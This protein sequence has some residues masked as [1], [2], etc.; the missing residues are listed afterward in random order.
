MKFKVGIGQD[1]HR[2]EKGI[3]RALMLG[4][5]EIPS[6]LSLQGNSDADLVL[7][8]LCNAIS[9]ISGKVI[10]GPFTDKLCLEKGITDSVE[11]VKETVKTLKKYKI[12]HVSVAIECAKPKIVPHIDKM[13]SKLAAI[14]NI[15]I[16]DVGITATSGE[17]LTSFGQ[18]NGIQAFVIVTAMG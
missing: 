2:F 1:S 9:G 5:I 10:I 16:E 13:R 8:A 7:H 15:K 6:D 3:K 11:Y 12:T 4:G 18:G 17:G 14:L